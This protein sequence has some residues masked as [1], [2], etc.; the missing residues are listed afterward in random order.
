[1]QSQHLPKADD[2]AQNTDLLDVESLFSC[3]QCDYATDDKNR[4]EKHDLDN[5]HN[6][7]DRNKTL[8]EGQE[9]NDEQEEIQTINCYLCGYETNYLKLMEKHGFQKHG[10]IKCET[11]EYSS[12]GLDLMRKH[13]M[14]HTGRIAFLCNICDF[15]FTK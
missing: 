11:C 8:D 6:V 9:R 7:H 4:M 5:I 15:E 3:D 12:E 2:A 13:M 14:K 10:I 1:M